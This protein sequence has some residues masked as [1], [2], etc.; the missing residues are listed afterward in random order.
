MNTHLA[1]HRCRARPRCPS[2]LPGGL[3]SAG[4]CWHAPW[5]SVLVSSFIPG[6]DGGAAFA[7]NPT[8][9]PSIVDRSRDITIDHALSGPYTL[10]VGLVWWMAGMLWRA[11][12]YFT[13][14]YSMFPADVDLQQRGHCQASKAAE[15][16]RF[17]RSPLSAS[18]RQRS[19]CG[20]RPSGF[21]SGGCC[22][23]RLSGLA[24][25]AGLGSG[26]CS[27]LAAGRDSSGR[28]CSGAGLYSG[29]G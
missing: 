6:D 26:R 29:R 18:D 23:G 27:G 25:G 28:G 9:L 14:V 20:W 10:H 22:C 24:C 12:G 13:L 8:L 21:C 11:F 17:M 7:L 5:V 2:S 15:G 16:V 1:S 3:P 4:S 19:Y